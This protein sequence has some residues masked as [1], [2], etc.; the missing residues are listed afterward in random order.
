MSNAVFVQ[1]R[2]KFP[3]H[4]VYLHVVNVTGVGHL[5]NVDACLLLAASDG[6][7]DSMLDDVL[8]VGKPTPD[9]TKVFKGV[10]SGTRVP[11]P[12][13]QHKD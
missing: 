7:D 6:S 2:F 4:K 12:T 10:C 9:V 13:M 8:Q 5:L 1:E 3:S 11:I